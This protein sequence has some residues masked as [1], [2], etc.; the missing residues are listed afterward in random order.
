MKVYLA[1]PESYRE[2]VKHLRGLLEGLGFK[3]IDPFETLANLQSKYRQNHNP[4]FAK[5]IVESEK[6]FI[7]SCDFV[8]AYSPQPSFGKDMEILH[9]FNHGKPVYILTSPEWAN[10]PWLVSH[11][12]VVT[13]EQ[14]LVNKLRPCRIALCGHMGSGKSTVAK[15]LEEK[16]GFK[17]YCFA[18]KLKEILKE[19]YGID[20]E[21][22]RFRE[23][24]QSFADGTLN[25]DPYVWVRLLCSRIDQEKP[26]RCV[27]DDLRYVREAQALKQRDFIIV[28]LKCSLSTLQN[29]SP[30]GFCSTTLNHPSETEHTKIVSDYTL[31]TDMG[32]EDFSMQFDNFM[33]TVL[34]VE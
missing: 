29:R 28:R 33:K 21:H 11:G 31:S 26:W 13:N 2:K 27:V 32:L 20:K 16:Y 17:R 25:I 1:H 22:S 4:L 30:S 6:E 18:W 7:E 10:H 15:F 34:R 8:V 9:G 23:I 3:V 14:T 12:I 24:A 19:L 5:Q